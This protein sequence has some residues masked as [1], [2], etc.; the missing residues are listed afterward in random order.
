VAK[1]D[2]H[3]HH[4]LKLLREGVV[5]EA[6]RAHAEQI[7][8]ELPTAAIQGTSPPAAGEVEMPEQ[9]DLQRSP[10]AIQRG[11]IVFNGAGSTTSLPISARGTAW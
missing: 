7:R 8:N 6:H 10:E 1:Q 2:F 9:S 3:D 11:L 4:R 5:G